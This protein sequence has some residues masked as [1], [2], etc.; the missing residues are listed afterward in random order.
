[1]LLLA[2]N[3]STGEMLRD[4]GQT[5]TEGDKSFR[6]K[7]DRE[8]ECNSP[9]RRRGSGNIGTCRTCEL[10][11]WTVYRGNEGHVDVVQCL[12]QAGANL[13]AA[14]RVSVHVVWEHVDV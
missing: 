13:D 8:S 14:E 3:G 7:N 6:S 12:V 9:G 2:T 5:G 1:M 11:Y 10:R 4:R